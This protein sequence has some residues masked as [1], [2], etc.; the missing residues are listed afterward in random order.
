[1]SVQTILAP[2][3]LFYAYAHEDE[4]LCKHLE[5]HLSSLHREG[6]LASWHD[7]DILPGADWAGDID[8]H[9]NSAHII[10]LLVSASFLAS[11]YCYDLEMQ[12]ALQRHRRGEA[13]VIPIILRPCDW[14]GA[15]FAKLRVL[16]LNAKPITSWDDQDE[17]FTQIAQQLRLL[18]GKNLPPLVRRCRSYSTTANLSRFCCLPL[19]RYSCSPVSVLAFGFLYLI[20]IYSHRHCCQPLHLLLPIPN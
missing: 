9:L 3:T 2:T 10:L 20:V 14:S 11:D 8:E 6:L 7:R 12:H 1:M 13:H 16:P 18:L 5:L 4:A 17:A 19:V 15:P